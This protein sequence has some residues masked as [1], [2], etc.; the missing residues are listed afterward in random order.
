MTEEEGM[1][2]DFAIYE[3]LIALIRA[4]HRQKSTKQQYKIKLLQNAREKISKWQQLH[5]R[6]KV[7]K[8]NG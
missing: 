2:V 3:Q 1:V 7:F 5:Y 8:E 4:Q 6:E